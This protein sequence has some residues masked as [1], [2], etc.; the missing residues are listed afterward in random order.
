M[1]EFILLSIAIIP[2]IAIFLH[3]K[4]LKSRLDRLEQRIFLK[5]AKK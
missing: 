4:K 3:V 1:K 2:Q 5:P